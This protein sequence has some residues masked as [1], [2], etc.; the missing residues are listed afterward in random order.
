MSRKIFFVC[1]MLIPITYIFLYIL[2]GVLR[3]GYNH[4]SNSVSE[5]LSQGAPNRLL[6]SLIN[7]AYG[8]L[9]ILFGF[10]VLQ[11]NPEGET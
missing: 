5:L 2:G 3:P 8:I 10:G 6:L 4:I 1:G 9:H 7:I 11:F